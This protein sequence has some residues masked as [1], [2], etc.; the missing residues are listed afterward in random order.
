LAG[1]ALVKLAAS[2]LSCCDAVIGVPEA[3]CLR[4]CG[5]ASFVA[6]SVGVE[7]YPYEYDAVTRFGMHSSTAEGDRFVFI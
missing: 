6:R 1:W 3:V 5:R 7:K 4:E 2:I